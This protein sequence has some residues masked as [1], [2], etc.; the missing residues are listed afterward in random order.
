MKSADDLPPTNGAR[1]RR[2][3]PR[4]WDRTARGQ[5]SRDHDAAEPRERSWAS[6]ARW[7]GNRL[8]RRPTEGTMSAHENTQLRSP[9]RTWTGQSVPSKAS[10]TSSALARPTPRVGK[11]PGEVKAQC[12]TAAAGPERI[13]PP[14]GT[15]N[16]GKRHSRVP[17]R[18]RRTNAAW[19]ILR[20][21]SNHH[22]LGKMHSGTGRRVP[23]ARCTWASTA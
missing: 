23:K 13:M 9:L 1:H 16:V 11:G 20:N 3:T 15:R 7:L 12:L 4:D 14:I 21:P 19:V 6:A 8:G 18:L 5:D 2:K 10:D 17:G 22:S